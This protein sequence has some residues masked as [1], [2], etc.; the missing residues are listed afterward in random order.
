[1]ITPFNL[2]LGWTYLDEIWT[3]LSVN[4][5]HNDVPSSLSHTH[6][7]MLVFKCIFVFVNFAT[8][9]KRFHQGSTFFS[10]LCSELDNV[11]KFNIFFSN[12]VNEWMGLSL[13]K[14]IR[15]I[16]TRLIFYY[17]C[18][19]NSHWAN[20]LLMTWPINISHVFGGHVKLIFLRLLVGMGWQ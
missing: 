5:T 12:Y 17:Y 11:K 9:N 6:L 3:D 10:F 20:T 13:L 4:W 1:M 19:W 15:Y 18:N 14:T 2:Q 7:D 8:K 16:G